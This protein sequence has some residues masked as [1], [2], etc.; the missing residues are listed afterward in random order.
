MSLLCE[1]AFS[2]VEAVEGGGAALAV[3]GALQAG[4]AVRVEVEIQGTQLAG[5][6]VEI[7]VGRSCD[8]VGRRR[9]TEGALAAI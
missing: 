9:R 6:V 8:V 4:L 3:G 7:G 2:A 1:V 5:Q